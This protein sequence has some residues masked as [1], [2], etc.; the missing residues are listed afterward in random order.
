MGRLLGE[1]RGTLSRRCAHGFQVGEAAL[2]VGAGISEPELLAVSV[3]SPG[4][5]HGTLSPDTSLTSPERNRH[6]R[7]FPSQAGLGWGES[8]L[9]C[10]PPLF[11]R[12]LFQPWCGGLVSLLL[13]L[14]RGPEAPPRSLQALRSTA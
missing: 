14:Q 13:D 7:N 1:D 3:A 6:K 8:H 9:S 10:Q 4:S 2:E 11:L 5:H 12:L